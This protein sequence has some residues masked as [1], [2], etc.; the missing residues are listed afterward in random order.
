MDPDLDYYD[1][2]FNPFA[3]NTPE[4]AF[5]P[6]LPDDEEEAADELEGDSLDRMYDEYDGAGGSSWSDGYMGPN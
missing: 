6:E 2:G 5:E 3:E 1:A 4:H